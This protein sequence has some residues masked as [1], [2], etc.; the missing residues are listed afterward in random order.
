MPDPISPPFTTRLI[1]ALTSCSIHGGVS[2]GF[3]SPLFLLR[4]LLPDS[5]PAAAAVLAPSSARLRS[6]VSEAARPIGC[7]PIPRQRRRRIESVGLAWKRA[8]RLPPSA[9]LWRL[10]RKRPP[11]EKTSRARGL[12]S[13]GR[14]LASSPKTAA[15][16]L[17][18]RSERWRPQQQQQQR[19][20]PSS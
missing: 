12:P 16:V 2:L 1:D 11:E 15:F 14:R 9:T 13:R 10:L 17:A 5:F 8:L 7:L 4:L 6:L 19:Q 18:V 20:Q 3:S